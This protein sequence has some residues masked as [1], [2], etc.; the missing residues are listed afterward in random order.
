MVVVVVV[1]V[2]LFVDDTQIERR[3]LPM[4]DLDVVGHST[5]SVDSVPVEFRR[6]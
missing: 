2:C 5:D 1:R 6:G 4:L 3:R